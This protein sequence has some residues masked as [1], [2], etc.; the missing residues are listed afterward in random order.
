MTESVYSDRVQN[1][2]AGAQQ[3]QGDC[4]GFRRLGDRVDVLKAC[5]YASN[6]CRFRIPV[7]TDKQLY[8]FEQLKGFVKI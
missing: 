4:M 6:S 2:K 3:S 1:S 5:M 8:I 7:S